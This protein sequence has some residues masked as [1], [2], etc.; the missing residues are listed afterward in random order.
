MKVSYAI[1]ALFAVSA[2]S[3]NAAM[4]VSAPIESEVVVVSNVPATIRSVDKQNNTVTFVN[5]KNGDL[6]TM[7]YAKSLPEYKLRTGKRLT[8]EL[9]TPKTGSI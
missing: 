5:R 4:E 3:A 1:V 8:L 2:V 7:R 9:S 6:Q